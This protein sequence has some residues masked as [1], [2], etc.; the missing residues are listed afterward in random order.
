MSRILRAFE[1]QAEATGRTLEG[2]AFR[3]NVPNWVS[4]DGKTRYR[5]AYSDSAA[6]N[7]GSVGLHLA[8]PWDDRQP[9]EARTKDA[10][11]QVNFTP[12]A[13]GL[14]FTAQV[15]DDDLGNAFLRMYEAGAFSKT[16]SI[17]ADI[18]KSHESRGVVY[19]DQIKVFELSVL[20]NGQRGALSG[21]QIQV[22]R[23]SIEC[24]PSALIRH[25]LKLALLS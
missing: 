2:L 10:F 11:G 21:A 17:G 16:V 23:N 18:L 24:V 3:T 5:E 6:L 9:L 25:R 12:T 19:R 20:P 8:H 22:V 13:E 7:Q 1:T 14:A 4:D 15:N